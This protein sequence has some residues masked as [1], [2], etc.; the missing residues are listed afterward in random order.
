MGVYPEAP[1]AH[2]VWEWS[3][4]TP[5]VVRAWGYDNE[6]IL[7]EQDED[8]LLYDVEFIPVLLEMAGDEH[9]PK[10]DYA[11]CILCQFSREQVTR[12]G[13][14]GTA[15][16]QAAWSDIPEPAGG[17]PREWYKYVSRLLAYTHPAGPLDK[18]AARR[19]A[20]ELLIGIA[21][22]VGE[23]TDSDPAK[24]GWWRFTLRT[25]VT[26]HVDVCKASGEFAYKPYY[27]T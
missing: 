1:M 14:R 17:R 16:I 26:E 11:F 6:L 22:R 13:K 23:I 10:Q 2:R 20:E 3:E 8:L 25:S 18:A 7:L 15:A 5:A 21:G 9:C 27:L 4:L 24:P 19:M 12:G